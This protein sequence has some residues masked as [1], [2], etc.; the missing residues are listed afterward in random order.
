MSIAVKNSTNKTSDTIL[1][2]NLLIGIGNDVYGP[3]QTSQYYSGLDIPDSGYVI[4]ETNSSGRLRMYRANNDTELINIVKSFNKEVTTVTQALYWLAITPEFAV[5]TQNLTPINYDGIKLNFDFKN[6]MVYPGS[7]DNVYDLNGELALTNNVV[8][9]FALPLSSWVVRRSDITTVTSGT[10]PPPFAGATVWS[11][12][13]NTASY[14][15]TLHRM[16]NEGTPNGIV[17]TIGNG[18]YKY[19]L[20]VRG[21][22]ANTPTC[23]INIDISDGAVS[24]NI[25]VGQNTNWQK[26]EV[27]DYL[28][29][30]SYNASKFFDYF[31]TGSNGDTFYISAIHVV[32]YNVPALQLTQLNEFPGYIPYGGTKSVYRQATLTNSPV[33][34]ALDGTFALDGTNENIITSRTNFTA[35]EDFTVSFFA[36]SSTYL[37]ARG[38]VS[39]KNFYLTGQGFAIGN[40]SNPLTVLGYV[41]TDTGIYEI[42]SGVSSTY[43]WTHF[44]LKRS[45]NVLSLYVNGAALPT[46]QNIL[47]VVVDQYNSIYVGSHGNT[48]FWNGSVSDLK[49]Y[50]R[51]LPDVEILSLY[52][53]GDI[54]TDGLVLAID[55]SNVASYEANTTTIKSLVG[56]LTGTLVNGVTYSKIK[57]GTILT[58]GTND[59]INFNS[60]SSVNF[61]GLAPFTMEVWGNLQAI[62]V[63]ARMMISREADAGSGRDGYN[64][65]LTNMTASTLTFSSERFSNGVQFGLN[66][67]GINTNTVLQKWVH[68][69]ATFDGSIYKLY[70]NGTL[71]KTSLPTTLS[72]NNTTTVLNVGSRN[73]SN[74]INMN[75][76]AVRVYDKALTLVEIEKNYKTGIIRFG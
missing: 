71:I 23:T 40:I 35:N 61:L 38:I 49:V 29:S 19:Y 7:G 26:I 18:Y 2:N 6:S 42:Q 69:V 12:K 14:A 64:M 73:G 63:G 58:D 76:G 32:A 55:P 44:V 53:H 60:N 15:N 59:T 48:S 13:I 3:T 75:F 67:T 70:L 33:F 65:I 52:H 25:L 45:S 1:K 30:G 47:G 50:Q 39:N 22:V 62:S 54:T 36:K 31:L 20:W 16:W 46:T 57:D 66:A 9:N 17:G 28:P 51:A 41:R 5:L 11:S 56:S 8:K 4:Y 68:Y 21:D 24:N 37:T 74:N 43:G 34:S 27:W 72:I 10:I